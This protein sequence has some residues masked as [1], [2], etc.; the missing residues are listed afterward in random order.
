MG[1]K[2]LGGKKRMGGK[3]KK[4]M[5][6][7]G[8]DGVTYDDR[9]ALGVEIHCNKL[10]IVHMGSCEDCSKDNVCPWAGRKKKNLEK[11]REKVIEKFEEMLKKASDDDV[12]NKKS[13]KLEQIMEK[14]K[15]KRE[16]FE[17]MLKQFGVKGKPVCGSNGVEYKNKCEFNVARCEQFNVDKTIIKLKRCMKTEA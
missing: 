11:K 6:I 3:K 5:K 13:K 12:S 16:M 9:C 4:E 10:K 8:S 14:M 2:K 1:G 15:S 17:K 7:C